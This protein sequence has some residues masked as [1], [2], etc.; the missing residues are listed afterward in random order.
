M[1]ETVAIL[2]VV[3]WL[4]GLVTGHTFGSLIYVL[5]VAAGILI[6]VRVVRSRRLI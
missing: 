5:L 2:L 6:V 3:I 4:L 1:L